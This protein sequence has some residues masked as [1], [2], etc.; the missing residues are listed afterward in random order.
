MSEQRIFEVIYI[1]TT[2][3]ALW[4]ALTNP[5][6]TQRYWF[7]TRIESDWKIGSKVQYL[8]NGEL[9]DEHVMLANEKHHLLSHTFKPLFGELQSEPP[10][11]VTFT[12]EEN[13]GVVRLTIVHESFPSESKVFRA[14]SDGWPMILCNLKTLLETGMP[15]PAF[16]FSPQNARFQ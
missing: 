7:D 2:L 8:R 4:D 1:R 5:D 15:L 3:V 14:C 9:T 16:T 13:G 12:M 11:R 10:S 6:V